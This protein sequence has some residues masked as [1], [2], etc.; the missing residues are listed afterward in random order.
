[1]TDVS[2]YLCVIDF[3]QEWNLRVFLCAGIKPTA[4]FSPV[5]S[6]YQVCSCTTAVQKRLYYMV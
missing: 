2:S 1:M 5:M 4:A 6:R 3:V